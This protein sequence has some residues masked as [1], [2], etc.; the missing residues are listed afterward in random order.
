LAVE[1]YSLVQAAFGWGVFML[2]RSTNQV[3]GALAVWRHAARATPR[4]RRRA[5]RRSRRA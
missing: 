4:A 2:G 3:K 5:R 1:K